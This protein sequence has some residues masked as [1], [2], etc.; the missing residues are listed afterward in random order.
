MTSITMKYTFHKYL[1]FFFSS[2]R[3]RSPGYP[4][5]APEQMNGGD[6]GAQAR[7]LNNNNYIQNISH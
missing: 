3:E 7:P 1:S 6:Q 2:Q 4:A 5:R